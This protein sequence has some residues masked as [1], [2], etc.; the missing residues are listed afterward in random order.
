MIQEWEQISE[1]GTGPHCLIFLQ[2]LEG[3]WTNVKDECEIDL[4]CL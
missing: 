4:M 1:T 3:V 2:K